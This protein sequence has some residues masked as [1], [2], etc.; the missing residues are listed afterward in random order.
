MKTHS[1]TEVYKL[2]WEISF[3]PNYQFSVDRKLFNMETGRE[4]K[5]TVNC[6]SIGY[7]IDRKFYTLKKLREHIQIIA[8][9]DVPF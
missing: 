9:S 8:D 6:Y 7:W 1:F 4:I 5:R 3:A 2:K